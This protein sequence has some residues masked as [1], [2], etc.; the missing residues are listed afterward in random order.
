MEYSRKAI[1]ELIVEAFNNEELVIFCSDHFREAAD[2]FSPKMGKREKAFL[3][4][5]YCYRHEGLALLLE[6]IKA[7]RPKKYEKYQAQL[8]GGEEAASVLEEIREGA[9][10]YA[11]VFESMSPAEPPRKRPSME[12]PSTQ[13]TT[14]PLAGGLPVVKGWFLKELAP[15]EQIFVMTV[16]LFSGLERQELMGIY[17][18]MLGM[19]HPSEAQADREVDDNG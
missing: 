5:E 6:K 16:A 12:S 9:S 2:S 17:K 1:R 11:D 18:D 19:L 7:E 13:E 10:Q 4:V 14:H 15:R 8:E 3:L